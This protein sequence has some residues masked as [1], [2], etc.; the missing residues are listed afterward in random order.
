MR[1]LILPGFL[2]SLMFPALALAVQPETRPILLVAGIS[3]NVPDTVDQGQ[4]VPLIVQGGADGRIEL[5]GPVT[6]TGSGTL[7][8]TIPVA[9]GRAQLRAGMSPGSYELRFFGETGPALARAPIDVSMA[10]ISLSAPGAVGAGGTIELRWR[11]PAQVGDKLQ[12]Y[13][14]AAGQV[15]S[16]VDALG[17]PGAPMATVL[18]APAATGSFELRYAL[19]DGTVL[20]TLPISVATGTDWLRS[21]L[22]VST[23]QRF[24]VIWN[25]ASRVGHVFR[26]VRESSGSEISSAAPEGP[27]SGPLQA[28]LQAP[29]ERGRYRVEYADPAAGTVVSA[30]PLDVD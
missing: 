14:P 5:W 21:P 4:D 8:A 3:I 30:Q 25:G 11:G 27:T 20:R 1:P 26:I 6:E 10:P 2:F 23:G 29:T 16:E 12:V 9:Q 19:A 22:G 18:Q 13:D 24:P 28:V 7:L 17:E 15:V